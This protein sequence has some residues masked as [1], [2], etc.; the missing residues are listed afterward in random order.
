VAVSKEGEATEDRIVV[1]KIK[2]RY[3]PNY[4]LEMGGHR[5]AEDR[6]RQDGE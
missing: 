2:L 6:T 3:R 4:R 5:Q 1:W